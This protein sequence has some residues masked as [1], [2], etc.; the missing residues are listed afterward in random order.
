MPCTRS[1][2][3]AH[4]AR[5]S[6]NPLPGSRPAAD[7]S[8]APPA[9]ALAGRSGRAQISCQAL[10]HPEEAANGSSQNG[11]R[12]VPAGP[13]FG[14]PAW[15]ALFTHALAEADRLGLEITL[16]I[17]SGWNLGGPGVTPEQALKLLTY[18]RT[19]VAGGASHV[20]LAAPEARNGFY[21]QIAVLAYP[22][23]HGAGLAPQPG[24]APID[25]FIQEKVAASAA[26]QRTKNDASARQSATTL[27]LR[28]A[29]SETGFSMPDSTPML[30]SG[31]TSPG[32][33]F[34][35]DPAYH[36]TMPTQI[37]DLTARL[38]PDGTLDWTP[39]S[40]SWE[41]L[42]VGYTDSGVK[43]STGSDTWTGLAIDYLSRD[44]FTHFWYENVEPLMAAAKPYRSLRYLATDSWEL[45]GTN[46]TGDFREEFQRLRGYDPVPWLPVVAGRIVGDREQST[47]F[48]TDLRRTVADLVAT[49]HYDVFAEKAR[50]HGLGIQAESGGP[51]G[52]PVDALETFR[53]A[54]VPQTEFWSQNGHRSTDVERFFTKEGASAANI[55]G[56]RFVAQEGETSI[57]PQ[58]SESLATDLK[59]SFDMAITEGMNRLVWHEFTSNPA[60]TGLPGQEY[61]AGT[62]L[63]PKITWWNAGGAFFDYLNRAQYLMQQ[64][65]PV[66]DVLYFYGDNVPNFVRLKSDDPARVLPGYDYDVTDE[67]ALLHTIR[68]DGR[69]LVGPGGVR[70]RLLALPR[71]RRVSLAVLE[72]T[73]RFV[74][75]GGSAVGLPPVSTTGQITREAQAHFDALAAKLYAACSGGVSHVYGAGRVFCTGDAHAALQALDIAPDFALDPAP[76][77]K[78]SSS[79]GIDYVHRRAGSTD[80]YFVRNASSAPVQTVASFRIAGRNAEI[81]DAVTGEMT[82]VPLA[83]AASPAVT[84]L[85]LNLPAFGSKAIVF[86][87]AIAAPPAPTRVDHGRT[88]P[89][90]LLGKWMLSFAPGLG[91]PTAPLQLS[92]LE[93]WTASTNPAVR[94]FSGTATYAAT[95]EAPSGGD[96]AAYA[97]Q[98]TEVHEIARVRINGIDA[99]TVWAAPYRLGVGKLLQPGANRI[100]I[101]V[102]NLWPNRIIGDAQPGASVP[103]THTNIAAYKAD[104]PLL[105]SGLIGAITWTTQG[106]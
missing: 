75:G 62:H 103:I 46:W 89:L 92:S 83:V 70:W 34:A 82:P 17:T 45:G 18:T 19:A 104:S 76:T 98:F 101:E 79:A 44:A 80:I 20:H 61:F 87:D 9:A 27:R 65:T 68:I 24:D 74:H 71:S 73:E 38:G 12:D 59:P 26:Q 25:H 16:N 35:G 29:A 96:L 69:E 10:R 21:R 58:W 3:A 39:P 54:G 88:A 1:Q 47:R 91:G 41:V 32:P 37:Q 13:K 93:S 78:P 52:A 31:V 50:E 84:T 42:V 14:S 106:D 90:Q 2:L 60:S 100:E 56:Q 53:H 94:Y 49:Q 48:L 43:V 30:N 95:V 33:T 63:N 51:H 6:K 67:D 66:D 97:L 28:A 72:L 36:D 102:T 99:G 11:N 81:W 85:Q 23:A 77:R 7:P 8:G 40:G 57:G 5:S 105:P 64:G 22:V 86:N 4:K 15:T 55:Y